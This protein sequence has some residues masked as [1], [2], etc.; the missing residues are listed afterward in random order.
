[1]SRSSSIVSAQVG[2]A[3]FLAILG[4]RLGWAGL[5]LPRSDAPEG[6]AVYLVSP[7]DGDLVKSP[8][9]V[10]FGLAGM[11]V[12]PAGTARNETG[13]HHL[14]RGSAQRVHYR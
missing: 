5:P 7:A 9:K 14:L 10:R 2:I 12:A 3:V 13:H 6:A 4:A 11:E 8:F 1:M